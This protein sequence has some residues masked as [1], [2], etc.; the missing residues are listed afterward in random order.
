MSEIEKW[1]TK[2]RK[3]DKKEKEGGIIFIT[4]V[5][6]SWLGQ[7]QEADAGVLDKDD[8]VNIEKNVIFQYSSLCL[9]P[10]QV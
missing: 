2:K 8:S 3:V 6:K 5:D 10:E 9:A 1:K 4:T 7:K